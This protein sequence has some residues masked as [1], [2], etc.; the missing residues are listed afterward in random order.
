MRTIYLATV[1]AA[2][3]CSSEPKEAPIPPNLEIL[4]PARS[5]VQS[6]A[7]PVT[8]T[9]KVTPN[10]QNV[11]VTQVSV[12]GVVAN[13]G[14]DGSFSVP[15]QIKPG[16]TLLHTEALDAN[17]GKAQDTRSVEAGDLE[18]PTTM[19]A[20]AVTT[21]LSKEAF[22]KISTAAGP[23]IKGLDMASMLA[24]YQP[25]VHSGDE[26]GPDCLFGQLYVENVKMQNIVISMSPTNGGLNFSA[27]I[28]GLDVPGHMTYK[29][30]CVGGTDATDVKATKVVVS[31]LLKVSPDGQNGFATDLQ[32]PNIQISGLDIS[33]GGVPGAILD[34]VPIDS[35]IQ[36]IMP[37]V[38]GMVMK[39]MLNQAL[40]A[41]SGPKTLN[42]LGK[43]ITVEVSPS[44]I[45]FTNDTALVTLDMQMS[46]GG[47]EQSKFVFTDNGQPDMD[48][49]QG[50]Q[51]G[52]ADDLANSLLSQAVTLG[53]MNLAMPV[54]GGSFDAS[55]IAMTSPPMISASPSD[56]KMVLVLPDMTST[57]TNA[58]TPVAK[59]AINATVDLQIQP[60][61][62]GFGIAIQLG[63]PN[64]NVD[65]LPDIAN[66][67]GFTPDDLSSAVKL[68]LAAQ[69]NTVSVLLGGI[70]LPAIEGIQMKDLSVVGADGYVM[71]KGALQ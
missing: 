64:I 31:G 23:I 61:S 16:A 57:F 3:A 47:A 42:L 37:K 69:I 52:I 45:N 18:N 34:I 38:A 62:D 27:E 8:V 6:G 19:L 26:N 30:A 58:G 22:A 68:T 70:P 17:G 39:P 9:G 28:D 29:V 63:T 44:A 7:A 49:G 56:G 21:A 54:T 71:V 67:T 13:V 53:L 48:P 33:S 50:M 24:P 12:N 15:V 66:V 25:M 40:G 20:D 10:A 35:L 60:S 43:S 36:F 5:L 2:S 55:S 59:A 46:I 65:V 11:P 1:L 14:A 51:L 4:S 41:L 32:N